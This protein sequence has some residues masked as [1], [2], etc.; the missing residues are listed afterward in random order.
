MCIQVKEKNPCTIKT[1]TETV[2]YFKV[3]C[4]VANQKKEKSGGWEARGAV[5]TAFCSYPHLTF[6]V[7]YVISRLHLY[8]R[9][10]S[11]IEAI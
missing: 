1:I 5:P 11:R 3:S 6:A 10:S 9:R 7:V 4:V 2:Y 8:S